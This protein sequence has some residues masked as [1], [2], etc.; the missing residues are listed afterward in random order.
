MHK[1]RKI[2]AYGFLIVFFLTVMVLGGASFGKLARF[3]INDEIDY[4]EWTVELGNKFETDITTNIYKK[5]QFI[6]L[7]GAIRKLLGQQEMNGVV[8]LNNDY[9]CTT[10]SRCSDETLELYADR[11]KDL[12]AFLEEK[13]I[14]LLYAQT[15][16]TV[17]KYDPQI[18]IGVEDYGNDNL[19]RFLYLLEERDID[20]IDFREEM[21][22]DG[23]NQYD[24][25]YKTDHHWTTEAGFYAYGK[26]EEYLKK[27]LDCEVDERVSNIENYEIE[28]YEKWHLGSN[29]QRTG[30]YYAGIDDFKLFVPK[31]ETSIVKGS[32]KADASKLLYDR[33][34]LENKEYT[35]RYTYDQ[36]LGS[37]VG[38]FKNLDCKNNKKILVM[39]DSM[40]KSVYPYLILGFGEISAMSNYESSSLTKEVI[41]EY[42][43]DA[44]IL[45]Y[46]PGNVTEE[47]NRFEFDDFS[48]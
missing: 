33:T 40:A 34:P 16:Y 47:M 38:N 11:V 13:D 37:S 8:K 30:I 43:P 31:F 48:R 4:N 3:Y 20:I 9:L 45:L 17:N 6:N 15:P 44:V 1:N 23:I 32:L 42:N 41:E 35:S 18:P 12:N 2:T 24:L 22:K 25:M 26:L 21:H 27:E 7:N 14:A 19:D 28:V 5:F 39:A 10:Y 36:V 29:G 46:Y